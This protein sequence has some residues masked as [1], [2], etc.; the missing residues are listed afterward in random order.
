MTDQLPSKDLPEGWISLSQGFDWIADRLMVKTPEFVIKNWDCKYINARI[1]MRTGKVLLTPGN[2]RS[3]TP[4]TANEWKFNVPGEQGQFVRIEFAQQLERELA[5]AEAKEL[6]RLEFAPPADPPAQPPEAKCQ[7]EH[8]RSVY[9]Q[10]GE[11]VV[12]LNCGDS[13]H[14]R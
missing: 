1:D 2:V 14:R 7:H 9:T 13:R 3:E 10:A 5:E 8:G 4:R 6:E 11:V 12:C